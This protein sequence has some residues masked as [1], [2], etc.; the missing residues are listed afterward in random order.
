MASCC[1]RAWTDLVDERSRAAV[2][3][4]ERF[5]DGPGKQPDKEQL[6][7]A[8]KEAERAVDGLV[9]SSRPFWAA[10]AVVSAT[11]PT[12]V[13]WAARGAVE[14]WLDALNKSDPATGVTVK[15]GARKAEAGAMAAL[16]RELIG[17]PFH[18]VV[19]DPTVRTP[20]VQ[21]LAQSAYEERQMPSGELDPQR[22]V[23]LAAAL[24]DAGAPGALP[25]HLREPGPHVRGCFAV[26]ACLGH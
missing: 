4:L 22:L 6:T 5:A 14:L 24:E 21:A 26:D 8:W 10:R 9:P 7:T 16:L 12:E 11:E 3:A 20:T 18:P 17:D 23:V 1:R 2:A 25:A 19:L 13:W 15:R